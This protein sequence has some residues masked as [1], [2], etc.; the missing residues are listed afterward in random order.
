M[1]QN[2]VLNYSSLDVP[3]PSLKL[4]FPD[5]PE[6]RSQPHQW[7]PSSC[8]GDRVSCAMTLPT[9]L[10]FQDVIV[11][12]NEEQLQSGACMELTH[13]HHQSTTSTD[14][15]VGEFSQLGGSQDAI[16]LVVKGPAVIILQLMTP[17][18]R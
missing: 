6:P 8:D 5:V 1:F 14:G 17:Q 2:Q 12:L 10:C 18:G 9:R 4:Q 16:F 15:Q 13:Q 11:H 7:M 3:E